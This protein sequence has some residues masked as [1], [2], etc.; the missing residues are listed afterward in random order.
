MV[1]KLTTKSENSLSLTDHCYDNEKE[2]LIV[3]MVSKITICYHYLKAGSNED[4]S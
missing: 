1:N 3:A 4:E 2:Y